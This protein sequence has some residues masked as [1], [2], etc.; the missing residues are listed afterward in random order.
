MGSARRERF[1]L[2]FRGSPRGKRRLPGISV[3]ALEGSAGAEVMRAASANPLAILL[4]AGAGRPSQAAGVVSVNATPPAGH[5][6]A[7]DLISSAA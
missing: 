2:A 6:A 5:A 4:V 3:L 7:G 1:W